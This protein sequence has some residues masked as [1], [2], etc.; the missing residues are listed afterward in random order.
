[1][2]YQRPD[3]T[4]TRSERSVLAAVTGWW[5]SRRG[6]DGRRSPRHLSTTDTLCEK[7]ILALYTEDA[8]RVPPEEPL[9]HGRSE[10]VARMA[11]YAGWKI[12]RDTWHLSE[13][14]SE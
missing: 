10:I 7:S 3:A 5:S 2:G 13:P 1:M 11:E 6:G 4:D 14:S 12:Y 9:I 8:V